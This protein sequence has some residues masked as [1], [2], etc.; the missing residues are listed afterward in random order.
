MPLQ[1]TRCVFM[2]GGTSKALMFHVGDL[3]SDREKWVD[4][5]LA[6]MGSPDEYGR[7]LD[8]MGGGISSLSKVC[9]IGPPTHPEADVDFLF[10]QVSPDKASVD[11]AGNCGNMTSAIGPFAVDEGLV[12]HPDNG[13]MTV[14]IH[15]TN[16]KKI[17]HAHFQVSHGRAEVDGDF[18]IDGVSGSGSPIRLDFLNPGG[19]RTRGILPSGKAAEMIETDGDASV[20]AS[21]VDA[22]N[23]SVFVRAS[24]FGLSGAESPDEIER[25]AGLLDRLERIRRAASVRMG[26]STDLA[27]AEV[28]ASQPKIALLGSPAEAE[29]LSGAVLQAADQDILC[30]MISMGRPHRAIPITGALCLAAACRIPGTIAAELVSGGRGNEIRIGHPSGVTLVD[31]EMRQT[32]D[33]VHIERATLYRTARRLFQGEV[34]Y[35]G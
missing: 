13:P 25:D 10:C 35:R 2:R 12:P 11:Y 18:R 14:R 31:A 19:A 1:A 16:T 6:A 9:V 30:R 5:F 20:E 22:A 24:D 27:E 21:L 17:I 26:M 34:L 32:P 29:L 33:G 8:G 28:Q 3:P 23:P 4:I 7:Q 15:N